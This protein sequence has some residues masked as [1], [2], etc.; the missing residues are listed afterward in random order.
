[1]RHLQHFSSLG[2]GRP[3]ACTL[4]IEYYPSLALRLQRSAGWEVRW[5][6]HPSM[7]SPN[8]LGAKTSRTHA[9]NDHDV[10]MSPT[11]DS[12]RPWY[13]NVT[14]A[15]PRTTLKTIFFF[16]FLIF[17][18]CSAWVFRHKL[19]QRDTLCCLKKTSS[20]LHETP[21]IFSIGTRGGTR[22]GTG[23]LREIVNCNLLLTK[24]KNEEKKLATS[25]I[26]RLQRLGGLVICSKWSLLEW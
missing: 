25:V 5:A 2:P 16:S 12:E 15:G 21:W 17:S 1:M 23:C 7:R 22:F 9:P 6:I 14:H 20:E 8:Y 13:K 4:L 19:W 11:G 3:L 26:F 18:L 24:W 10:K